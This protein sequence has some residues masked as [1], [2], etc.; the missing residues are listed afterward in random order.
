MERQ[1]QGGSGV[2]DK[3]LANARKSGQL[4][5]SARGLEAIP[6]AVFHLHEIPPEQTSLSFDSEDKWWESTDLQRLIV[7]SNEIREIPD[8]VELLGALTLLDAH[9]NQLER[10][11]DKLGALQE[12]K[13][14]N[15]AHN[16][17]RAIPDGVYALRHLKSLRL[18]G[19]QIQDVDERIGA[20]TDLEELDLAE[21]QLRSLPESL[22]RLAQLRRLALNKNNLQT[23]PQSIA[24]LSLITELEIIHNSLTAVPLS[25][26]N[27]ASL[28]RLDL[29]YNKLTALPRL[30]NLK[31]LR[32]LSLGFNSI[33]TLG[34][35][36]ATLP[37][38][39]CILDVRDNKLR[40]LS[41]SI[42][43]LQALERLD[44][45]NNDLATL[46]PELGVLPKLKSI[47]LDGNPMRS[48][49][50]DIIAR[51]TQG[52]LKY[53]RS[54]M[55][56]EQLA[57]LT[58]GSVQSEAS[59]QRQEAVAK[60]EMKASATLDLSEQKLQLVPSKQ[61]EAAQGAGISK[62]VLRK[63]LLQNLPAGTDCLASTLTELDLGFNK[64]DTLSPSIALLGNLTVLDLQG[65]QLTS[66][67]SELI[68]LASL[69]DLILSFNRFRQLPE[70]V[71]DLLALENLVVNDN[72]ID[73][74][75]PH[76]LTRMPMLACLDGAA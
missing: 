74:L 66:L 2:G 57:E 23:L 38:G 11:S 55:T 49:R 61:L 10:V 34:D 1:R 53:L 41:P 25:L 47:V 33:T 4:N 13:A 5:I 75:D 58:S 44:V 27:M 18:T 63:N 43:H 26:E 50:R 3:L 20:L 15:F 59:A 52:I 64:I 69:R 51:G 54:R 70:C 29:R 42:V 73:T 32:E 40:D 17:L 60:A 56:E 48:L 46:P 31:A 9:N 7:A 71:Y 19:N 62:L 24:Q 16:K 39:L 14:L 36:R 37:S 45:T 30:C 76:G 22:G 28:T 65:N 67:P 21:N 72:A 35:I 8:D 68:S 12:L 6:Q